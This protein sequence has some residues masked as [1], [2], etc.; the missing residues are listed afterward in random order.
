MH[1]NSKYCNGCGNELLWKDF[2]W[3][4]KKSGRKQSKCKLCTRKL[5]KNHYERNK[6]YYLKKNKKHLNIKKDFVS[7]LKKVKCAD[8]KHKFP[9]E[10]MDFDHLNDDKLN[11]VSQLLNTGWKRLKEEIAKCEIVCSNCHRIRTKK[12]MIIHS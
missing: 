2:N 11:N 9:P 1:Q 5:C 10:C 8:C 6:T 3:K 4:D 12:R 7:T